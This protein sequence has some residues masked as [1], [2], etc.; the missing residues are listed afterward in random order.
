MVS[1]P[2]PSA[3][4]PPSCRS[5]IRSGAG[6]ADWDLI[7]VLLAL[8]C[9]LFTILVPGTVA[10]LLPYWLFGPFDPQQSGIVAKIAG[11]AVVLAGATLYVACVWPFARI[12]R[13]TPAPIDAP[14][15]LVIIGPYRCI[16]NPM[17]VAVLTVIFGQALAIASTALVVYGL[18]VALM[19]HVVVIVYE[20]I[21]LAHQFG[22][23]YRDYC[24]RVP[25]WLPRFHGSS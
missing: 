14:I 24:R 6:R 3:A 2:P 23:E 7:I 1:D 22:E 12:G 13:G 21:A 19:F 18:G 11:S 8:K 20:E 15:R 9:V 5:K 17:Y 25:R 16:R 10:G 4:G